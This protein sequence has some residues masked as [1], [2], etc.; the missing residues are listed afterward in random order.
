MI[1]KLGIDYIEFAE[2]H[3]F[4]LQNFCQYKKYD[5]YQ[6]SRDILPR[7]IY[8]GIKGGKNPSKGN[9]EH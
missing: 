2:L 9:K 4:H 7:I 8:I 6:T 3:S 5:M 1:S